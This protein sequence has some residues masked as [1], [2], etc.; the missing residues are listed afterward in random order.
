MKHF[1]CA[2]FVAATLISCS[3]DEEGSQKIYQKIAL[4]ITDAQNLAVMNPTSSF[5]RNGNDGTASLYKLTTNGNFEEVSFI[6]ADGTSLDEGATNTQIDVNKIIDLNPEFIVL[7]GYFKVYDTIGNTQEY[8]SLLVGK[9]DGAIYNFEIGNPLA[10]PPMDTRHFLNSKSYDMDSNDNIYFPG[11]SEEFYKLNLS[12][13]PTPSYTD[14]GLSGQSIL[15][16]DIDQQ[17]NIYYNQ[18]QLKVL[19]A[20]GGVEV[21]SE[22]QVDFY[23]VGKNNNLYYREYGDSTF[24]MV[25]SS[26][27]NFDSTYSFT[28]PNLN[29]YSNS[30]Y[31]HVDK[32]NSTLFISV[33]HTN[34]FH[35]E[36][37]EDT[38]TFTEIEL[39]YN[40]EAIIQTEETLYMYNG[41]N[42]YKMNLSDNSYEMISSNAYEIYTMSLD[43]NDKL[44]FS[45]LRYSD[46]K[47][48]IGEMS[49]T[50][51]VTIIE[52]EMDT[53]AVSLVRLD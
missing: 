52:E 9:N 43:Q 2:L 45:G 20:T 53:E 26:T 10:Q 23:W 22:N 46:G 33:S 18:D 1:I 40:P 4:D 37:S 13:L 21:I 19:K 11:Y 41:T 5:G 14:I 35:Y 27:G 7:N 36:F 50:G 30:F 49:T 3:K 32:P 8:N 51:D 44:L 38:N 42:V 29:T 25:D 16:Y 24:Y 15:F 12:S 47:K 31:F 28:G 6:N 34:G 39:P 48:V 17:G